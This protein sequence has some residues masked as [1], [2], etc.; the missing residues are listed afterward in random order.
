MTET[1]VAPAQPVAPQGKVL[2]RSTSSGRL[3][4]PSCNN[5]FSG[6]A[7]VDSE[8]GPICKQ[9]R[10]EENAEEE[11]WSDEEDE[12]SSSSED[13]DVAAETSG[14]DD[15]EEEEEDEESSGLEE[16]DEEDE[17]E[18]MDQE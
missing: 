12:G 14:S 13:D 15:E 6:D 18:D 16:V 8:D 2:K 4:C 10:S 17:S 7:H 1:E 3:I 11:D 9:C 5:S